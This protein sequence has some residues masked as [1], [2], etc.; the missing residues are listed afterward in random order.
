MLNCAEKTN[1][2]F[3]ARSNILGAG[4]KYKMVQAPSDYTPTVGHVNLPRIPLADV[5]NLQK[6]DFFRFLAA[7]SALES[8]P[9]AQ[10]SSHRDVPFLRI[11]ASGGV[12]IDREMQRQ[13][14]VSPTDIQ[15]FPPYYCLY[16]SVG[17]HAYESQ[18]DTDP[19]PP[20]EGTTPSEEVE[21]PAPT[22]GYMVCGDTRLWRPSGRPLY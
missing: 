18:E 22:T 9:R 17:V 14:L 7:C 20:A 19:S 11:G 6:P 13:R 10:S 16:H 15:E 12:D 4:K 21:P 1:L 8:P 3:R 5:T 2:L